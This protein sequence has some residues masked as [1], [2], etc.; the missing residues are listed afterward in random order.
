MNKKRFLG[1]IMGLSLL[2]SVCFIGCK[3]SAN[4]P[5]APEGVEI[6]QAVYPQWSINA[7]IYEVNVRQYTPEGTFAAFMPHMERL[8]EMGVDILWFMPITPIGEKNRKGSLGSYYSV[9]D[10]TGINPEFG[11]LDDF[12]KLVRKAHEME[13]YVIIDWVAN[14]T[15]WDHP[16][17]E[18][19]PEFFT[20]DSLGNFVPPVDDW[21]DVIDLDYSNKELRRQMTEALK[22]W[23]AEV[24]ID[25]FRCDVADMV[26]TEFWDE[27][28]PELQSIKPVFMLAEAETPELHLKAFDAAYGWTLHHILNDIAKG[29]KGVEALNQYFFEGKAK[30]LP[31][32]AY[33][34]N[35]TS[36]HDE[37]SWNGTE[38]ERLGEAVKAMAVVCATIPGTLLIYNGQEAAFDRR[39]EFFEK[40]QIDWG[41]FEYHEFYQTLLHLKTRNQALWNGKYGG[42]MKKLQTGT[43]NVF[44]FTRERGKHKVVVAVNMSAE[45][46]KINLDDKLLKGEFTNVFTEKAVSLPAVSKIDMAPWGFIVLESN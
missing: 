34:M 35:F 42:D 15:A 10:Y 44:A 2:L 4:E 22:F 39:L 40:D 5:K 14:H 43:P 41:H 8:K 36:N 46:A 20:R 26:P 21:S 37:N 23:V 31:W 38:F 11:T 16:W 12:K 25:G 3:P 29:N 18:T 17:T 33:K 13:M 24:G 9:K 27:A 28:V 32:G 30:V 45:P 1:S 7:N 19:N 6:S